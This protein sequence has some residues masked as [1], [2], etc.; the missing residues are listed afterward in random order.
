MTNIPEQENDHHNRYSLPDGR[1]EYTVADVMEILSDAA[2]AFDETLP[3]IP[4]KESMEDLLYKQAVSAVLERRKLRAALNEREQLSIV[5]AAIRGGEL[6]AQAI[7]GERVKHFDTSDWLFLKVERE[8]F[9]TFA[10]ERFRFD[11]QVPTQTD[12]LM[13]AAAP[14]AEGTAIQGLATSHIDLQVPT[15]A[16]V[17]IEQPAEELAR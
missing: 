17:P 4:D 12:G 14:K 6:I 9:Q 15:Q 16:E 5:Q 13:I 7:N 3:A 11:L 1:A 10:R 8:N 2:L